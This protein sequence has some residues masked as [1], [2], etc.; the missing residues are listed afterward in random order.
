MVTVLRLK[1][2]VEERAEDLLLVRGAG[3]DQRKRRA[4][5]ARIAAMD[6]SPQSQVFK[7]AH[8]KTVQ[9]EDTPTATLQRCKEACQVACQRLQ[10]GAHDNKLSASQPGTPCEH[11]MGDIRMYDVLRT[12]RAAGPTEASSRPW[13]AAAVSCDDGARGSSAAADVKDEGKQG[14]VYDLYILQEDQGASDT[15]GCWSCPEVQMLYDGPEV[16]EDAED[17]ECGSNSEDSNAEMHY[18]HDYPDE[19]D[20]HC[21]DGD[22]SEFANDDDSW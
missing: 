16:L 22:S 1:R 10:S 8:T 15:S 12:E 13:T 18:T 4:L 19:E 11:V 2:K 17:N 7:Y 9:A 21:S 5:S 6:L 3:N 20:S 14:Y